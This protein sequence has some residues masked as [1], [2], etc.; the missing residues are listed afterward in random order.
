MGTL[1]PGDRALA[2]MNGIRP[3]AWGIGHWAREFYEER[4]VYGAAARCTGL[5]TKI[6]NCFKRRYF[7]RTWQRILQGFVEAGRIEAAG[8]VDATLKRWSDMTPHIPNKP[9]VRGFE[10]SHRLHSTFDC[11][12]DPVI[13]SAPADIRL[14]FVH[15][16]ITGGRFVA[17]KQGCG[18]HDLA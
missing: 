9:A 16:L 3:G 5:C 17:G 11:P 1:L 10:H 7:R 15:Y 18:A 6:Y 4:V 12:D 14:H 13:G 8:S 2:V